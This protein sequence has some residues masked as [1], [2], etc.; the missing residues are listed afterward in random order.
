M[1]ICLNMQ[2][3]KGEM[4]ESKLNIYT[5]TSL[6]EIEKLR[7]FWTAHNQHPESDIDFIVMLA[8]V[9]SEI[10]R[11][12]IIVA[13]VNDQP[14]AILVGR[15]EITQLRPRIGYFK[16][17]TMPVNQ[18]VFVGGG[19]LGD[20]SEQVS[21]AMIQEIQKTLRDGVADRALIS[22]FSVGNY[23]NRLVKA[24]FSPWCRGIAQ[25][26]VQHWKTNL[27]ENF[28]AFLSERPKKHRYWLRRIGKVFESE[29]DCKVK[30]TVYTSPED[31]PLFCKAAESVAQNTYQ[32]GLD[33]GFVDNKENRQR[34]ALS[35]SHGSFRSYV[36]FVSDRPLAFWCGE[37]LG[38]RFYLTWTGF[39]CE[40]RKYEIGTI[41]YLKMV[42]D[43]LSCGIKEIDYGM[44][45]AQYKER[46]GDICL[47][48]Q[49]V[50]IYATRPKAIVL[51]QVI[52]IAE[53]IN[54]FGNYFLSTIK[55]R[56]KIKKLWRIG[57]AGCDR[58]MVWQARS[59]NEL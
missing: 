32:R 57:L 27:P 31:V 35:A 26:A 1:N 50:I 23:L 34:L 5:A 39:N 40:Y 36:V 30:Y 52:T 46:F 29:F 49:D 58:P 24:E 54:R 22:H 10:I 28:D 53:L 48:N 25:P 37:H 18:F 16:L 15:L 56:E 20:G 6:K 43:L 45:W 2:P 11:P 13:A 7:L 59:Q 4:F 17:P 3:V 9:R 42:R 38:G 55:I 51:N 19:V 14:V 41:L 21:R 12:H 44:G 47:H 8:S 33:V